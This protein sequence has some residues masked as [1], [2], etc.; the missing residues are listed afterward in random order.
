MEINYQVV[1][2][3]IHMILCYYERGL[4]LFY[5][6]E[7]CIKNQITNIRVHTG[8][9]FTIYIRNDVGLFYNRTLYQDG[10]LFISL[11]STLVLFSTILIRMVSEKLL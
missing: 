1:P 4:C 10:Q 11:R 2:L 5:L 9:Y 6:D 8:L 3:T 7:R